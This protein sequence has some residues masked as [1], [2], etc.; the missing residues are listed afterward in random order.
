[1]RPPLLYRL[2]NGLR[3]YIEDRRVPECGYVDQ[4][5]ALWRPEPTKVLPF[6]NLQV[7]RGSRDQRRRRTA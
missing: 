7:Q 3:R 6:L 1:M 5:K 4:M 2:L